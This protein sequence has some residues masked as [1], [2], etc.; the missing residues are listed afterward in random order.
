[1]TT[2]DPGRLSD[3]VAVDVDADTDPE[4]CSYCPDWRFAWIDTPDGT[5]LRQWHLLDCPQVP[6]ISA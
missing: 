4:P 6:D 2:D 5:V 3:L 1:M